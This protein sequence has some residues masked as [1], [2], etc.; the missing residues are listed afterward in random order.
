V[1]KTALIVLL[2]ALTAAPAADA[3]EGAFV[4]PDS[5]AGTEYALPLERARG[6]AA[7]ETGGREGGGGRSEQPLFGVGIDQSQGP[8]EDQDGRSTGPGQQATGSQ[9]SYN[10]DGQ[11]QVR[12]QE[13]SGG[14]SSSTGD[15]APNAYRPAAI[16]AAASEGSDVLLTGGIAAAVLGVGFFAGFWLRRLLR[17]SSR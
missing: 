13:G 11:G 3:Q 14:T 16:E 7:P 5:P 8:P 9:G 1:R 10:Q 4:D 12:R 15:L 17:D 6:E 2:L